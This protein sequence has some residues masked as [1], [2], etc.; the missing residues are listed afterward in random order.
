MRSDLPKVMH[1]VA[2]KPMVFYPVTACKELGLSKIVV[3]IGHR[4]EVVIEGIKDSGVEFSEQLSPL[5]TAHAVISTE[6]KMKDWNGDILILSGDVP[7]ITKK[8]IED[9]IENHEKR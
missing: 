4:K 3:V 7:L 1:R 8:T 2:G 6:E 9:F 5:G